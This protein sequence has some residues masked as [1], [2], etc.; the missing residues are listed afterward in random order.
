MLVA[1]ALLTKGHAMNPNRRNLITGIAGVATL[2]VITPDVKAQ[3]TGGVKLTV[4][5]GPP[6]DLEAFEK[7]Y[8]ETHMPLIAAVKGIRRVEVSKGVPNA[9]GSAPAF[10][11]MFEAWFDSTEHMAAIT[12]TP[13][14]AKVRADSAKLPSGVVTRLIAKLD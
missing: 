8:A 10:Y 3:T 14:W 2:A 7:H 4:L 1:P 13:E 12:G 5:Y 9:D 11:R 6:Q